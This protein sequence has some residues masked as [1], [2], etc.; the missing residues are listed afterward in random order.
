M[1]T[2][3]GKSK[4]KEVGY[5]W[6]LNAALNEELAND[7][8]VILIGEDVGVSGGAFSATAKLQEEFGEKR[9]RDYPISE[10]SLA[11]LAHGMAVGGLRPII[12]LMFMDFIANSM[13]GVV[14]GLAKARYNS[15]GK[16]KMPVTIM[17]PIGAGA[18]PDHGSS[19][20]AWFLHIPGLKVVMPSTIY[21]LKGLLKSS[22]RDDNPVLFIPHI[23]QLRDKEKIPEEEYT[24]PLGVA[25]I[26][27]EGSD[28]TLVAFG[29]MVYAALEAAEELSSVGIDVEVLDPRTVVPLDKEAILSSVRKTSRLVTVHEAVKTG[30]VGAEVASIVAEEAFD[31]L[32]APIIRVG[33]PYAPIP[34]AASL[35]E[36]YMPNKDNIVEAVK[37]LFT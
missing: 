26:K 34:I 2:A 20:E 8:K 23:A 24:I 36:A 32:D 27:R 19:L 31:Y 35:N 11:H 30:G 28:V 17:A 3:R 18:G 1:S 33:A 4:M 21:D 14:N 5:V 6:A 9:V 13:S 10:A 25:D 37:K 22:V 15:Y 16:F 12:E 7:E 29:R